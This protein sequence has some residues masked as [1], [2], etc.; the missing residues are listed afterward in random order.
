MITGDSTEN[1]PYLFAVIEEGLRIFP[2][3]PAGLQR[4]S[5]GA[6]VDGHYVPTGTSVSSSGWSTTHNDRYFLHAREF[7]PERWLPKDHKLYDQQFK[8]DVKEASR[9]FLLGPRACLGINLAYMEMRVILAR[10]V[11]KFDL[12]L[13]NKEV[14]W[15][16]DTMLKTLWQNPELPVRFRAIPT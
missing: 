5:P 11:W 15:E 4:V 6:F 9:P 1:L 8:N 16:R 7:C 3:V 13:V 2:P 14:D 10:L 12:E